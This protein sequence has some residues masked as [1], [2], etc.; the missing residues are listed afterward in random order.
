MKAR[1]VNDI[2]FKE[3]KRDAAG[4][5]YFLFRDAGVSRAEGAAASAEESG[6]RREIWKET[7]T[8]A[9]YV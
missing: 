7:L 8:T 3:V 5:S 1:T 9:S 4:K 6:F 2:E